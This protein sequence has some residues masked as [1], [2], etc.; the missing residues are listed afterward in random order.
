MTEALTL[1]R[2]LVAASPGRSRPRLAEILEGQAELL[3]A[4][5]RRA[6]A[7]AAITEATPIREELATA[8]SGAFEA[9]AG[10]GA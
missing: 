5:G 10:A 4:L 6:E 9:E 2:A 1:C 7:L 3:R 8:F